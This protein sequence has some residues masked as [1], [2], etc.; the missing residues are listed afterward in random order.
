MKI[1]EAIVNFNVFEG[2]NMKLG[3]ASATMP[4]IQNVTEQISGAGIPGTYESAIMGHINAMT[5]GLNFRNMTKDAIIL[6][7]QRDHLIELRV[8]TQELDRIEGKTKITSY[9]HVMNVFP[10]SLNA[11]QVAPASV[12]NVSGEYT[13]KYWKTFIN[14]E[15]VLEIDM[16]N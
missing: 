10:K 11:G 7:E 16:I 6:M 9:K 4:T 5:L 8:P 3:L 13:V 14:G 15:K 2:N 12:G 1:S